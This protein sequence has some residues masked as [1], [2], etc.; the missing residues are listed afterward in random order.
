MPTPRVAATEPP[1]GGNGTEEARQ[2]AIDAGLSYVCDESPGITRRR[3]GKGFSYLDPQGQP[4]RDEQ[5]LQRVR[6][7]AVPPAYRE[8]WICL[9]PAGHLQATG[10]DDRGRKQYRYHPQWQQVRGTGKFDR[11]IAFGEA[12]PRLRR[13]LR[14]D[15]ALPEFPREKVLAMVVSVMAETLL[16]VGNDIYARSNK[17]FGLTTLRNRHVAFARGGRARFKF[18]GKSGLE[19]EIELDDARLAKL[20]RR[21]RQLPGQSLFQYRNDDGE[22]QPVDSSAVN[23]YIQDAMGEDFTAKDFRTWG[24]TL[25]AFHQFAET[26]L[27]GPARGSDTPSERALA[28]AQNEVIKQVAQ[29]LGN[30][31]AVCRSAYVAPAVLDGWRDGS[32]HKA[33]NGA[34][35]ARQWEQATLRFLKKARRDA[36]R[37]T[38][39]A[40]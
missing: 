2:A 37:A 18:R 14:R 32:L 9:D 26:P 22:L 6:S 28:A 17:S 23:A 21:C 34:R 4:V 33:A 7:L 29:V 1:T 15:L 8:V 20:I 10:R 30:T 19:H 36:K 16:R 12:L 24:G 25:A 39:R 27:P 11:V 38:R 3:A 31:P 35:G 40:A 5:T 13:R